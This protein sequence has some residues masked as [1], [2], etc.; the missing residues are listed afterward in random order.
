VIQDTSISGRWVARELA[1]VIGRRGKP[2][3]VV[4]DHGTEFTSNAM[5]SRTQ[6]AAVARWVGS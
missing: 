4:S 5:L 2:D 1:D 3:L 6:G